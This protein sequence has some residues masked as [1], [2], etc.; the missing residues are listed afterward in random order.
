MA[1]VEA[2]RAGQLFLGELAVRA[3]H[4]HVLH[5][6]GR[7]IGRW[8]RGAR[9]LCRVV[10][11]IG[12]DYAAERVAICHEGIIARCSGIKGLCQ[13]SG[14]CALKLLGSHFRDAVNFFEMR[15][16]RFFNTKFGD[17]GTP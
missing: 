13:M 12:V 10:F 4:E 11:L 8:L 6:G 9:E 5:R 17:I 14:T 16:T 7:Q 1:G 2:D 15:V 3:E